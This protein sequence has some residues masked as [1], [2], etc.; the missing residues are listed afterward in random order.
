MSG[1]ECISYE[2]FVGEY[3][4]LNAF[5]LLFF[6][7]VQLI[8]E[9]GKDSHEKKKNRIKGLLV[10]ATDCEPQYLIRL[11]QVVTRKLIWYYFIIVP[12]L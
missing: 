2:V 8:Q 12:L 1:R 4:T 3:Y 7:F 10:A 9:S 5:E 11:L 6:F